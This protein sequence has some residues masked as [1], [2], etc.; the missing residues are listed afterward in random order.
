MALGMKLSCEI[1]FFVFLDWFLKKEV[2]ARATAF[3]QFCMLVKG[4]RDPSLAQPAETLLI[5]PGALEIHL[6]A[7]KARF[8][9]G[10]LL[11]K[12]SPTGMWSERIWAVKALESLGAFSSLLNSLRASEPEEKCILAW[13]SKVAIS[14]SQ[15]LM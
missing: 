13:G 8:L 7:L 11:R 12:K 5:K 9:K 3:F 15:R 4:S 1:N 6:G 10:V 14:L 2:I